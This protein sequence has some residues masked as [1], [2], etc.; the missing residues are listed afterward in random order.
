MGGCLNS[1]T[2]TEAEARCRQYGARLCTR[3]ELPVQH[4]GGCGHEHGVSCDTPSGEKKQEEC[5][6]CVALR[7]ACAAQKGDER[8]HRSGVDDGLL[9]LST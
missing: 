8:R 3:A 4:R 7:V 2:W 9:E 6:D 1:A 5:G